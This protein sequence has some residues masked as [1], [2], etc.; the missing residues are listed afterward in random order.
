MMIHHLHLVKRLSWS[1]QKEV[2]FVNT[3]SSGWEF[4]MFRNTTCA[5]FTDHNWIK[6]K[7]F[8]NNRSERKTNWDAKNLCMDRR[9]I[10]KL[11]F[12]ILSFFCEIHIAWIKWLSKKWKLYNTQLFDRLAIWRR[13]EILFC[14]FNEC[15]Q[16]QKYMY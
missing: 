12:Q 7:H 5:T 16:F 6:N 3:I 8:P 11:S 1:H 9:I 13:L 14:D 10:L 15:W 4:T 2:S